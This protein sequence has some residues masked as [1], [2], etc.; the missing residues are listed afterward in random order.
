[1]CHIRSSQTLTRAPER[2]HRPG[3]VIDAMPL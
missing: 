1:V 3:A 2:T